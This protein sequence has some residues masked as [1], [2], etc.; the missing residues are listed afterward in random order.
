[1]HL[2]SLRPNDTLDIYTELMLYN[3][4]T[5]VATLDTTSTIIS[6]DG[7]I[8]TSQGEYNTNTQVA[9]LFSRSLVKAK[10]GNTL[11]GDTLFY[12]RAAGFGRAM[13]N[14]ELVA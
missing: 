2:H 5:H 14:I 11:T 13:G 3:T 4:V 12:D 1:M 10:N 7:T 8:Y 9:D 6:R